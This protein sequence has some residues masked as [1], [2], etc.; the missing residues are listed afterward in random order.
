[1]RLPLFENAGFRIRL[2]WIPMK[3]HTVR[4]VCF[5]AS[6]TQWDCENDSSCPARHCGAKGVFGMVDWGREAAR[7]ALADI[8]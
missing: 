6:R 8:A 5:N 1:M 3:C 4:I 2:S 7:S